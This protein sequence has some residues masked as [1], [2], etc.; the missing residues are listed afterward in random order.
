MPDLLGR[1]FAVG[2]KVAQG[3]SC[4]TST[5]CVQIYTVT[6]INDSGKPHLAES[7]NAVWYPGRLLIVN[8]VP[9]VYDSR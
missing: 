5:A 3:V 4:S 8:E 2:D 1:E 7:R 6:K 9:G